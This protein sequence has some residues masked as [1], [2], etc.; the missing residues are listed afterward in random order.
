MPYIC[1]C[2][3]ESEITFFKFRDGQRCYKCKGRK[4]SE[5]LSGPN[6][7]LY[8]HEK[9]DEERIRD[10]KYR[11][12]YEW[13]RM[14]YE[15]DDYTCQNCFEK[16]GKINAHHIE[17][18]SR[19]EDLRTEVSNGITLCEDCH[20]EYH[21]SFYRNDATEGTFMEFL[22]GEHNGPPPYVD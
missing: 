20:K 13:R 14:V 8:K 6:H 12:Y 11:E 3:T 15:R 10:R 17:A 16:G 4:I 1:E 7:P 21:M 19:V 18:Y 2:G 9:S 5:K 22:R